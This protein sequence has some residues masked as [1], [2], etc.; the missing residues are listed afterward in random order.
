MTP[1]KKI[2]FIEFMLRSDVLAFGDFIMKS[3]R[4][5]PY[6]V[7]T[8]N[9]KTGRQIHVLGSYYAAA[10]YDTLQ[11]GFDTMFG[12]AY[13]GIPLVTATAC[14]LADNFNVDKPFCFNRKESK[15]HGEHGNIVGYS[16][17]S[18]DKLI[19]IEDVI[20]AGTATRESVT[21]LKSIAE[22]I[23]ITDMFVSFN[24]CEFGSGK[25]SAVDE[26]KELYGLD[27]HSLV[28]VFDLLR[29]L[30]G[31]GS[32]QDVLDKMQAHIQK[33]CITQY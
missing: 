25:Q 32:S 1:E 2:E 31:N 18:G 33:Y 28:D 13:K 21:L 22:G 3:G 10:V 15:D 20:T 16:P 26:A 14:S 8:G 27:I 24:R 19:I 5:S 12:P 6:F 29:Y 11:D 17:K 9:Y 30:E 23:R 4:P 7:N